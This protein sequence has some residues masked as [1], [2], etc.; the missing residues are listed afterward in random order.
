MSSAW[1]IPASGTISSKRPKTCVCYEKGGAAC[2]ISAG[3][4]RAS[5][6]LSSR[7][8]SATAAP[9]SSS[10]LRMSLSS[11]AWPMPPWPET[12]GRQSGQVTPRPIRFLINTHA[13]FAHVYTNHLFGGH[14][15]Q[16]SPGTSR[17]GSPPK[18]P[19][20]ARCP[21]RQFF[22]ERDRFN[23]WPLYSPGY[24]LQRQS[25]HLSGEA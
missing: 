2:L 12:C 3:L 6:S 18:G 4:P 15:H 22:Q 20:K 9:G 19:G 8:C 11:T 23:W 7:P 16:H 25:F 13:H 14:G 24:E 10:A 17:D 5:T 1:L 21:V